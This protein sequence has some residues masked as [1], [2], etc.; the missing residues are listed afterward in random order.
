MGVVGLTLLPTRFPALNDRAEGFDVPDERPCKA[1]RLALGHWVPC[2]A[3]QLQCSSSL[4]C[5]QW[6]YPGVHWQTQLGL[7]RYRERTS[8]AIK[9]GDASFCGGG[10][11]PLL[12]QK[13]ESVTEAS[14]L[15]PT[16]AQPRWHMHSVREAGPIPGVPWEP[17]PRLCVDPA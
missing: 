13:D 1:P 2:P 7:Q 14:Q 5:G 17:L 8:L 4:D 16:Q 6:A 9:A 10:S 3:K 11:G 12:G 15:L